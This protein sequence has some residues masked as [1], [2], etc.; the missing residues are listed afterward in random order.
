[1]V[2]HKPLSFY[3]VTP[4]SERDYRR[5]GVPLLAARGFDVDVVDLTDVVNPGYRGRF[6]VKESGYTRVRRPR[7][8][9]EVEEYVRVDPKRFGIFHLVYDRKT[10]PLYEIFKRWNG[11]YAASCYNMIPFLSVPLSRKLSALP[12][13]I[14]VAWLKKKAEMAWFRLRAGDQEVQWPRCVLRGSRRF[15]K[16]YPG[17]KNGPRM[18]WTHSL[19]YDL[20]LEAGAPRRIETPYA[21]FLDEFLPYH[22]DYLIEK[23]MDPRL[24]PLAYYADLNRFFDQVERQTGLAVIVAAHPRSRYED[25]P[26]LFQGRRWEK[27]RTVELVR[28]ASL[29][30]A[31]GS[32][33]VNFAVLYRKPLAFLTTRKDVSYEGGY[34]WNMAR[35]LGR[36]T[37]YID[38]AG[39]FSWDRVRTVDETLF[40]AYEADYIKSPG[41]PIKPFWDIVASYLD[42]EVFPPAG[43]PAAAKS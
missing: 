11:S 25:M 15:A 17:P 38:R 18:V 42:A 27:D 9:R 4:F 36:R 37:F 6:D 39:D 24:D 8:W 33:S 28:D 13:R 2:G 7:S 14:S 16:H 10:R 29:V 41:S 19:D 23:D 40:A 1:M 21:V 35:L 22:P 26:D 3:S 12:G 31:H 20:F 32:T 5:F 43:L 34:L 30:M